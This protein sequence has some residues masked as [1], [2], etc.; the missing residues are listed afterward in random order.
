MERGGLAT[1]HVPGQLVGY[2]IVNAGARGIAVRGVVEGIEAGLIAWL[3]GQGIVA[4]R[5]HGA[6]GVWCGDAKIAAVGLHFRRGVSLHGF[7]LNLAPDLACF[8]WIVP[9][10]LAGSPV[11]S[12][13]ALRG[14][15]LAPA[16]VADAVAADVWSAV[17]DT[18]RARR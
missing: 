11:T 17:V 15:R 2:L 6:P 3:S 1:V 10:G 13:A 5:R 18:P 16:S 7:A 14:L 9:C 12:I 4:E 8:D